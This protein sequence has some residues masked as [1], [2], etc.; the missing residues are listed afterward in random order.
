M[1]YPW[2]GFS[3]LLFERGEEPI[4]GTDSDWVVNPSYARSRPLGSAVDSILT[5]AIGSA[6]RTL[7]AYFSPD[8]L[9]LLEALQNTLG[10]FTDW[11][12]PTPDTRNAVLLRVIPISRETMVCPDGSTN[13]RIRTQLEL[14]SQ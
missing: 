9:A 10:V 11:E 4:R 14:A 8:R 3:N 1:A 5:T 13:L 2:A 7:Q 12:R 6:T